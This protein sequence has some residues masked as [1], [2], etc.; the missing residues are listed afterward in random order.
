[1]PINYKKTYE[2]L[3]YEESLE[4]RDL[5]M[6]VIREIYPH[7][8]VT[9][10]KPQNPDEI[11]VSNQENTVRILFPLRDVYNNFVN[12]GKTRIELKELILNIYSDILKQIDD[13]D[14][15]EEIKEYSWAEARLLVQPR[16]TVK[17]AFVDDLEEYLYLPFG[18][19][20]VT[21]LVIVTSLENGTVRQIRKEYLEKWDV[22]FD[23]LY[24][25]AIEN[26][27]DATEGMEFVG[28]GKPHA[29]LWNKEAAPYAAS[30]LL[31]SQARYLIHQ[32]IGSPYRFGIPSSFVFY[33]WTELEDEAFQIEM[34]ATIKRKYDTMPAALSTEI[35]EVNEKGEIKIVKDIPE[36]PEMPL[37]SNN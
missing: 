36:I 35:Y 1:M 30:T 9:P 3:S 19:D 10:V 16:L 33:C 7:Y 31:I 8:V 32:T 37:I 15:D 4:F 6:G 18:E 13:F 26:F 23:E 17:E 5:T 34:K 29:I 25:Q 21:S 20:L 24:K 27:I 2:T 28:T 22:T 14:I 11:Y 12:I